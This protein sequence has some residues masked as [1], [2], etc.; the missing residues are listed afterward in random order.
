MQHFT[1][2]PTISYLIYGLIYTSL[3]FGAAACSSPAQFADPD[4]QPLILLSI[5]GFRWDYMDKVDTPH[6]DRLA[7]QGVLASSLKPVFPTKTFPNHYTIVTGLYPDHHGIV[8]NNMVDPEMEE[9]FSLGN[10]AA[11]GD[12]AWWG[13]EP[14]WVTVEKQGQK[15]GT[16]FWPGSEADIQ[17]IRP[18][19]WKDYDGGIPDDER[20][21]TVLDWFSLP[22]DERPTFLTLYFSGV[23]QAGHRFGPDAQ[24]TQDAISRVDATVGR[25]ISGLESKQMLGRVNLILVSDH[26]MAPMTR[27]RVIFLDDYIDLNEVD[28]VDMNP[29][30]GLIPKNGTVQ[31]LFDALDKA[32]PALTVYL[33]A[34]MPAHLHYGTHRRVPPLVG[35][36]NEGWAIGTRSNFERSKSYTGGL[37]G[38]AP[39]VAS[40]HG[41]FIAHGPAFKSG[42]QVASIHNLDIYEL[43]THLLDL[44]PAPN[45]GSLD[46]IRH[47]L[48]E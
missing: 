2:H 41:L 48:A 42:A 34:N 27:E 12:G 46:D 8:S 17:G 35:L 1:L 25:L 21:D 29:M 40:M 14:I 43:M 13:G 28:V 33:K 45:D 9:R 30:L 22:P 36:A 3:C 11:V 32:H 39:N 7:T 5:D 10:R 16:F 23:D 6:L 47:I 44:T 18:S 19:Y 20:V 26:G 24:E 4:T 37:H 38:Y 15:A 31:D